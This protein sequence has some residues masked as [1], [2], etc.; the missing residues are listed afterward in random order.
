MAPWRLPP[1]TH[2]V[3]VE[4]IDRELLRPARRQ[5]DV[6]RRHAD[7]RGGPGFAPRSGVPAVWCGRVRR[8]LARQSAPWARLRK[9]RP[10][11]RCRRVRSPRPET[12]RSARGRALRRP[13]LPASTF[14]STS[15]SRTVDPGLARLEDEDLA[16]LGADVELAVGQHRRPLLDRP[17]VAIPQ[18]ACR[19]RGRRQS[20]RRRCPPGRSCR[21]SRRRPE[22][23]S[24]PAARG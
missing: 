17:E 8:G 1:E 9:A 11:T 24:R 23:G 12:R 21:P 14:G 10:S 4:G 2:A 22:W 20:A 6:R 16:V 3:R 15:S 18:R 7:R 5:V 19:W 13:C